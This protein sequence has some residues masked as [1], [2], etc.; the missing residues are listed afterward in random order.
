MEQ[1]LTMQRNAIFYERDLKLEE[2]KNNFLA[3]NKNF[4]PVQDFIKNF[5]SV[6][7]FYVKTNSTRDILEEIFFNEGIVCPWHNDDDYENKPRAWVY[8]NSVQD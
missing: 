4:Q 3:L 7:Y 5:D 2:I 6:F 1:N 8:L